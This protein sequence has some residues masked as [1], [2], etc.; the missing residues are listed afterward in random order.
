MPTT[1]FGQNFLE[2]VPPEDGSSAGPVQDGTVI[3]EDRVTTN[4]DLQAILADLGA[5]LLGRD[6]NGLANR[7]FS[8][9]RW[10][11]GQIAPRLHEKL[12]A[13]PCPPYPDIRLAAPLYGRVAQAMHRGFQ[14][15]GVEMLRRHGPLERPAQ[16]AG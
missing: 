2:L 8:L 7:L 11:Q 6:P 12:P 10:L 4:T 3:P 16:A 15:G 5:V 14:R 13:L 9:G 1:L